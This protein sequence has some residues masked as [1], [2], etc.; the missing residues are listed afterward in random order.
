MSVCDLEALGEELEV[1][2]RSPVETEALKVNILRE[3]LKRS[4]HNKKLNA[5][6]VEEIEAFAEYKDGQNLI[7]ANQAYEFKKLNDKMLAQ[8]EINETLKTAAFLAE[9]SKASDRLPQL[10]VFADDPF[11]SQRYPVLKD[12]YTLVSSVYIGNGGRGAPTS[13]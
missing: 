2:G 8:M 1:T 6:Y 9:G 5:K 4:A 10:G 13:W 12:A 11:F 7:Q 3:L